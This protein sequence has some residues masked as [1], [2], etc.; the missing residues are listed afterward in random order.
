MPDGRR[1]AESRGNCIEVWDVTTVPPTRSAAITCATSMSALAALRDGRLAAGC[2]NRTV[3]VVDV[4]AGTTVAVLAGHTGCVDALAVLHDGNLA[5]ASPNDGMVRVWDMTTY[6]CIATLAGHAGVLPSLAVLADGRL[7]Y[8]SGD[9]EVQ[10]W[11]VRTRTS[12]GGLLHSQWVDALA[13]LPDGRL[14]CASNHGVIW[15]WDTRPAAAATRPADAVPMCEV[16]RHGF[17]GLKLVALPDG[18][19]VSAG[20]DSLR[21]WLPP[22]PPPT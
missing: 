18:R 12:A 14:A 5:S 4:D 15:V 17:L 16:G 2:Y 8:G 3:E 20:H 9:E 11:D 13:A 10:L 21:V 22:P 6:A 19:L 1:V 7:A